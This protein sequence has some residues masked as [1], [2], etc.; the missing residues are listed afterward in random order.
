MSVLPVLLHR[1]G[2]RR[3]TSPLRAFGAPLLIIGAITV[4]IFVA[5]GVGTMLAGTTLA[6]LAA[7][8]L[9]PAGRAKNLA[10]AAFSIVLTISVAEFALRVPAADEDVATKWGRGRVETFSAPVFA[11]HPDLG[12][13]AI[14]NASG[15]ATARLGDAL[16]FQATYSFDDTG[17]R[18]TP[19]ADRAK[20]P[21]V[22]AGDS[23]NFG[24]GLEDD[25]TLA[26]HLQALSHHK[27]WALNIARP[28]Y[29][30]HQ[31]LRQIELDVPTQDGAPQFDWLIVSLVDNH[32][33]RVNGRYSWMRGTPRYVLNRLG[34][35]ERR[36]VYGDEGPPG[37]AQLMIQNSRLLA[38]LERLKH[39]LVESDDERRFVAVLHEISVRAETK[40]HAHCLFLYHA[41]TMYLHD[42]VGR[43]ELMHK[44][45]A[46]AGIDYI[47]VNESIPGIDA[48]Y[49]I[50]NDGH[51]SEKLNIAL[52][53]LVL[54]HMDGAR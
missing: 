50:D 12:F 45:F 20:P 6:A 4:G 21:I 38:A 18:V 27:F 30:L 2:P 51:P 37:R 36:G 24:N 34:A 49:F 39:R 8:F 28:G 53:G 15:T 33:E 46:E 43:R 44:L 19:G 9:A 13:D 17:A 54:Q 42:L 31:V 16:V 5:G 41:G 3:A 47:D 26:Y 22:V 10:L 7:V 52:A 32:I 23:F 14:P 48:S 40:Y 29:G 1:A 35:L 11:P 25:Q